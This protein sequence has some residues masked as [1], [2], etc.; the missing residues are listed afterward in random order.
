MSKYSPHFENYV[1]TD[2]RGKTVERMYPVRISITGE[3]AT[4]QNLNGVLA[5]TALKKEAQVI[6][7]GITSPA[8]PRSLRVTGNAPEIK[9]DVIIHGTNYNDDAISETIT[10]NGNTAVE[11]AKAF[12]KVMKIELPAEVNENT[13]TVS[14]G[15]G[16]K[17]GL[18]YKLRHNTVLKAYRNDVLEGTAPTVTTNTTALEHNTITLSSALN[19]TNI[20][21]YLLV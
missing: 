13:D 18:P 16:N 21:V 15:W 5:A 2:V 19:G 12:K 8:A 14:I 7:E 3:K 9:G 4:A 10:L 17:L 20:D 11:S 1:R 6:S